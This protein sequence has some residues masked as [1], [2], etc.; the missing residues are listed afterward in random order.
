[1]SLRSTEVTGWPVTPLAHPAAHERDVD[2]AFGERASRRQ[3]V[4]I[5]GVAVI[6]T[7]FAATA[8][9]VG[10]RGNQ[11][12]LLMFA[13]AESIGLAFLG[14]GLLAWW[15]R[16]GN[17]VGPL[18]V[19][20]GSSWY[21]GNLQ[22]SGIPVLH[23]L[24][25]WLY[26]LSLVVFA[27][28]VLVFPHGFLATHR[29]GRT[30]PDGPVARR[31]VVAA[32]LT[33]LFFQG[34]RYL[35]EH[36]RGPIGWQGQSS[37]SG[38][39]TLLS[40]LALTLCAVVAVVI[41]RR[42]RA[43][44]AARRRTYAPAWLGMVA[45]GV[46]LTA[47]TLASLLRT[48]R[49]IAVSLFLAFGVGLVMLPF[50]FTVGLLRGRPPRHW[51]ANLIRDLERSSD[52]TN[53]RDALA[54]ALGDPSLTLGFWSPDANAYVD[55]Y[56]RPVS[57]PFED[58]TR[59]VT[60]VEERGDGHRFT[61]LVHDAALTEQQPL[62]RAAAAVAR[63][64]LDNARLHA[65]ER[66]QLTSLVEVALQERRRIERDLHDGVQHH[67]LVL[68]GLAK[69]ARLLA[70]SS[71]KVAP[72]RLVTVLDGLVAEASR[73]YHDLRELT[74]GI[75]P[76]ILTE[77][78]L[79]VAVEERIAHMTPPVYVDLPRDRWPDRVEG[80]AFF[81]IAEALSN[82]VKHA[83]ATQVWIRGN[84]RDGQLVVEISDDG[85]GGADP[86]GLAGLRVRVRA[87]GGTLTI[88]SPPG[89]GTTITV[90]LP[91]A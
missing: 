2:G 58:L 46:I 79:A 57:L 70:G 18:M 21:L 65:V 28:V 44:G 25:Y 33:Y 17:Q 91:C 68:E 7:A 82:V 41:V 15:R 16:P 74:L 5:V 78:G 83:N 27:H 8:I 26:Y 39:A 53:V 36:G 29:D 9:R 35:R 77:R 4:L 69:Q 56:G 52:P 19:A 84:Q 55:A 32:Y 80:T 76:S 54:S 43:A 22:A 48:P 31:V 38:W 20:C 66:A 3:A 1:M 14:P 47:A 59:T 49:A 71:H 50:A 85:S 13:L 23:A 60:A 51:V 62:V 87:L 61:V 40:L 45:V 88:H 37:H 89:Q 10:L 42:W 90:E 72:D 11:L 81:T 34:V 24:G 63:L 75:H 73:A 30:V 12:S 86:G 6:G 67:L 64:A